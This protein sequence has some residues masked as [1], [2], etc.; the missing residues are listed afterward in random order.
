VTKKG[1][2]SVKLK[3]TIIAGALLAATSAQA[4]ERFVVMS[5]G[6]SSCG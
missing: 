5:L 1:D 4:T 6:V 2:Q 3:T